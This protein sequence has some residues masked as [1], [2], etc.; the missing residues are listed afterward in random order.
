MRPR[1]FVCVLPVLT[2]YLFIRIPALS[3]V[4]AASSAPSIAAEPAPSAPAAL[5]DAKEPLEVKI[6]MRDGLRF[7]P[8]RFEAKP[9]DEIVVTLENADTTHQPHNFLVVQPG[10]REAVVQQAMALGDKG[11]AQAFVPANPDILVHSAV[12]N[13]DGTNIVRFRLPAVPGVYPYVCTM[14]GHG[15]VMYGAI[16]SGVKM[17][18]LNKD[19]NI[20]QQAVSMAIAGR[21]Q[22]PYVQ[23]IFMPNAGPAAIAVALPGEQNFCWDAGECRLRYAWRGPFIDASAH[24]RGNGSALAVPGA[25]PWWSAEKGAFPLKIGAPGKVKF[26]GYKLHAGTPEFH[27]R[28]GDIEVFEKISAAPNDAGLVSKFRIPKAAGGVEFSI[29]PGGARWSSPAGDLGGGTLKL[30][31][32]QAVDFTVTVTAANQPPHH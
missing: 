11:P 3:L 18:A 13:P 29:V 26:L 32:A 8:P 28:V 2:R 30:T 4:I 5:G 9:G 22:R 10:K 1:D 21:G 6:E 12:L 27:Y 24:W 7:E 15:V 31:P 23:R 16:Y 25:A 19:P 20:P 17:P 14:P